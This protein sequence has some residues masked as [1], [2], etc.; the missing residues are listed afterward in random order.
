MPDV[1]APIVPNLVVHLELSVATGKMD[2]AATAPSPMVLRMLHAA[3]GLVLDGQE[4]ARAK[5][6]IETTSRMPEA[7]GHA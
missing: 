1:P 6:R 5:S 4:K 7:N 3:I 2:M